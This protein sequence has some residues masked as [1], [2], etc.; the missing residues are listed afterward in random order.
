M[1]NITFYLT[2]ASILVATPLISLLLM[3][4]VIPDEMDREYRE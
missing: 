2:I 4:K 3:T 1:D